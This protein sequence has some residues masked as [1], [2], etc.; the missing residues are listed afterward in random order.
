M[1]LVKIH[2]AGIGAKVHLV[3]FFPGQD[4]LFHQV[5]QT[6]HVRV[7]GEG[8]IGLVGRIVGTAVGGCAQGQN[9]PVALTGLLQPVHKII[10]RLVKTADAI[11]GGQAGDGQQHACV[12]LH[13]YSTPF[14]ILRK[15]KRFISLSIVLF[16]PCVNMGTRRK[17]FST[18]PTKPPNPFCRFPQTK[19]AAPR[20]GSRQGIYVLSFTSMGVNMGAPNRSTNRW[21]LIKKA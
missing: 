21:H 6:D 19:I 5:F 16:S 2:L 17:N 20:I 11:P 14:V 3:A 7:S 18:F 9:L 8:G 10:G 12:S 1:E 13:I 15:W 4:P